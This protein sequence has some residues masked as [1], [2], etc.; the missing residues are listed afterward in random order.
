MKKHQS[1]W[2]ND[3][4]TPLTT[5]KYITILIAL[6]ILSLITTACTTSKLAD[7]FDVAAVEVKAKSVIDS[8]NQAD[9]T[10]VVA[11]LREDLREAL[12]ADKIKAAVDQVYGSAG[13][14]EKYEKV[15]VAGQKAENKDIA[16]AVVRAK[17]ADYTVTFTISFDQDLKVIGL[18][19]K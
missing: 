8:L 13:A 4:S 6:L 15:V 19:M 10:G 18:Y 11:M 14:F 12:P 2:T 5:K 3:A 7:T 1:R 17:Y 9:Y 16:V